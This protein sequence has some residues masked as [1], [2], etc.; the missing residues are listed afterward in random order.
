MLRHWHRWSL[1]RS[2]SRSEIAALPHRRWFS[3]A[4]ITS[5]ASHSSRRPCLYYTCLQRPS[6]GG[7]Y[8][9]LAV[10]RGL[11]TIDVDI[12][13]NAELNVVHDDWWNLLQQLPHHSGVIALQADPQCSTFS[14]LL[15][16]PG[17]PRPV[18]AASGPGL[19]GLPDLLPSR[20]MKVKTDTILALRVATLAK[21]FHDAGKPFI[22]ENPRGF[23]PYSISMSTRHCYSSLV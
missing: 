19:Y 22:I 14:A 7:S 1:Q 20:A 2:P 10:D 6:R 18:R 11:D 9:Q 13:I 21:A 8:H 3:I 5:S 15:N 23:R 12:C 4:L 16:R 17:G